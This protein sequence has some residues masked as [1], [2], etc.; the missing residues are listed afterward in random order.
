MKT[1]RKKR[2]INRMQASV[3]T[4]RDT[5]G[6]RWRM[7]GSRPVSALADMVMAAIGLPLL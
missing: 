3:Y 4:L 5:N 6:M 1:N 7:S 2:S